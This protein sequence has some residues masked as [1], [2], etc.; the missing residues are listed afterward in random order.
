MRFGF[1]EII[2]FLAVLVF[3]FGA[4]KLPTLA[5]SVG[6]SINIFKKELKTDEDVKEIEEQEEQ[7]RADIQ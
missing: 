5:K 6:K 7:E 3:L 4:A 1:L 2:A